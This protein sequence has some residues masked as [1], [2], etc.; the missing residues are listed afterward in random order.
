MIAIWLIPSEE[1]RDFYQEIINELSKEHNTP[2]FSPHIT[3]AAVQTATPSQLSKLKSYYNISLPI[4]VKMKNL[5]SLG[6]YYQQV[7]ISGNGGQRLLNFWQKSLEVLEMP[8]Y[9][10]MPHLSLLYGDMNKEKVQAILEKYKD[11]LDRTIVID[12]VQIMDTGGEVV[13]WKVV[14]S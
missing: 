5:G 10:F 9:Q 2:A 14:F 8:A 12:S 3:L 7:F 13:D 4:K 11:E 1:D 6:K